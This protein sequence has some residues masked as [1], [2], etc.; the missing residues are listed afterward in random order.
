MHNISVLI[1]RKEPEGTNHFITAVWQKRIAMS[2]T[3]TFASTHLK[4]SSGN[5]SSAASAAAATPADQL[6][7]ILRTHTAY[8][9]RSLTRVF[10]FAAAIMCL[11]F[12]QMFFRTSSHQHRWRPGNLLAFWDDEFG[13]HF[14]FY[15]SNLPRLLWY[16]CFA[17]RESAPKGKQNKRVV[18]RKNQG[19][20]KST[21]IID[22][23]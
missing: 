4:A 8:H 12:F 22:W 2:T 10:L 19:G 14:L 20:E 6:S 9:R 15:C 5:G 23:K 16:L 1:R 21:E 7:F 3:R 11:L 17:C 18:V 13:V